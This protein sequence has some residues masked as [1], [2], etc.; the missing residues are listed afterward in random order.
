M[1]RDGVVTGVADGKPILT[2]A[3]VDKTLADE[4]ALQ[5]TIAWYHELTVI[6]AGFVVE[7]VSPGIDA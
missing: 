1:L 4:E 5:L 2:I 6:F 7:S 3:G